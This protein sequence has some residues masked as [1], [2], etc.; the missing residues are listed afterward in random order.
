MRYIGGKAKLSQ[1]YYIIKFLVLFYSLV[2]VFEIIFGVSNAK[3]IRL[4]ILVVLFLCEIYICIRKGSYVYEKKIIAIYTFF[5]IWVAISMFRNISITYLEVLFIYLCCYLCFFQKAIDVNGCVKGI[6]KLVLSVCVLYAATIY[7]QWINPELINNLIFSRFD[8]K[9]RY[10]VER[11]ILRG[12]FSGIL[13]EVSTICSYLVLGIGI[14]YYTTTNKWKKI[15]GISYFIFALLLTGKRAHLIFSILALL[16]TY[17]FNSFGKQQAIR[18]IKILI[19]GL[20]IFGI[21]FLV[22]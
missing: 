8:S 6:G 9:T 2:S 19:I 1:K 11:M 7:L 4:S 10:Y 20:S 13:T 12:S 5:L 16:F 21:L 14:A 18:V 3:Y 15:V 17:A 22:Y